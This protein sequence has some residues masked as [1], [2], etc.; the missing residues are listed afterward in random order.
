MRLKGLCAFSGEHGWLVVVMRRG[1]LLASGNALCC[2]SQ[3]LAS[4]NALCC[5]SWLLASGRALRCDSCA[6]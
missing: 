4:G 1:R 5:D 6:A 3:L 2:D